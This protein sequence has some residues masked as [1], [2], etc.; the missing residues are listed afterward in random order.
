MGDTLSSSGS[1]PVPDMHAEAK[2]LDSI[3][4]RLSE[5]DQDMLSSPLT[6]DEFAA[7]IKHIKLHVSPG[8]DGLTA[9]FYQVV[10]VIF[11]QCLCIVIKNTTCNRTASPSRFY[12]RKA[13][14]YVRIIIGLLP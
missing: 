2:L 14:V 7:F 6:V 9:A 3:D 8:M 4:R 1:T 12:T 5:E 11:C 10:P 13:S